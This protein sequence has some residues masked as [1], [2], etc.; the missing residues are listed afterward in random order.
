MRNMYWDKLESNNCN[1]EINIW[2]AKIQILLV[3]D[4]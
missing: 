4:K 2:N 1:I 3:Y